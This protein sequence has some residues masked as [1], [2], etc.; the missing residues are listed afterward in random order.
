MSN[1]VLEHSRCSENTLERE[2]G[3][4]GRKERGGVKKVVGQ[5]EI[6]R[7]FA[8]ESQKHPTNK[9]IAKPKNQN[10]AL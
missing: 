10:C 1:Q 4:E 3:W 9:Q 2:E 6:L 7:H 5:Q 8:K